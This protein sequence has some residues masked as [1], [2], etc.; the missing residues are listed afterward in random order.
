MDGLKMVIVEKGAMSSLEKLILQRCKLLHSLPSS[1]EHLS[2]L[3]SLEFYDMPNELIMT[4]RPNI[5]G[6]DYWKVEHVPEINS[7]YWKDGGWDVLSLYTSIEGEG[8]STSAPTRSFELP[9]YW[10]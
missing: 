10:K 7:T 8:G 1:I 3:K 6:G 4:L 9:P 2:K 5:N